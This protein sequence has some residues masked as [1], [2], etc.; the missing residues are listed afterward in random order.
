MEKVTHVND[1]IASL[2][3]IYT[4]EHIVR[5]KDGKSYKIRNC[6]SDAAVYNRMK[7]YGYNVKEIVRV[8]IVSVK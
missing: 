8:D 3:K 2:P 7:K 4:H 1:F 5:M 6:G